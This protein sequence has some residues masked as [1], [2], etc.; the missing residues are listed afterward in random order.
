[1][2]GGRAPRQEVPRDVLRRIVVLDV[3]VVAVAAVAAATLVGPGSWDVHPVAVAVAIAAFAI[4]EAVVVTMQL[5]GSA[6]AFSLSEAPLVAGLL[7]LPAPVLLLTRVVGSAVA[8]VAV[9]RQPPFKVVFNLA[10][11]VAETAFAVGLLR[12]IGISGPGDAGRGLLLVG[13]VA[14]LTGVWGSIYMLAVAGAVSGTVRVAGLSREVAEALAPALAAGAFGLVTAVL[15]QVDPLLLVAQAALAAVLAMA[16]RAHVRLARTTAGLQRLQELTRSLTGSAS[17]RTTAAELAERTREL[18]GSAQAFVFPPGA[19]GWVASAP[20]ETVPP[21]PPVAEQLDGDCMAVPL[22]GKGGGWLVASGRAVSTPFGEEERRTLVM[23]ANHAAVALASA[24][25]GD[26]LRRER[27]EAAHRASHDE[28]TGL[29]NR[30]A[31]LDELQRRLAAGRPAS[32]IILDLDDFKEINDSLGHSAGDEM[33][34]EVARRYQAACPADAVLAR[35]GGDEFAV[36]LPTASATEAVATARALLASMTEPVAVDDLTV[37]VKASAGVA[38]GTAEATAHT[39]LQQ[40]DIAMYDAKAG[41]TGVRLYGPSDHDSARRQLLVSSALREALRDGDVTLAYQPQ[42]DLA[43]RRVVG[44]EAL[45]RWTHP[46]LGPVAPDEFVRAAEHGGLIH[47]LSAFVL[48]TAVAQQRAWADA[49]L[50][51]RMAVNLSPRVLLDAR[52]PDQVGEVLARHGVAPSRLV[53]ELTEGSVLS[54]PQRTVPVLERLSA[55]GI[56]IALDDFGTGYSSLSYL[57]TLPVDQL[58]IDKS[59]VTP[60]ASQ[61]DARPLVTAIIRLCH[62]LDLEV[63]AEGVEDEATAALLARLGCTRIQGWF[64]GRPVPA[65]AVPDLVAADLPELRV[66]RDLRVV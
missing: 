2:T 31:V 30:W 52:L 51:L 63:V 5:G 35:L 19:P 20:P 26:A 37:E 14:V 58:K 39:L 7:I 11:I 45:A 23:L 10:V 33:L 12:L 56:T 13:A 49:G 21:P 61:H 16:H 55:L 66:P 47:D 64:L 43:T 50:D 40:A 46:E 44:V 4:A 27:D 53:L 48:D 38:C 59:F 25:R 9:R 8:L 42:G 62:D 34:R 41:G 1:M 65:A 18:L 29:R 60:L 22:P 36:L 6:Q 57:R 32:L 28:L 17:V 24:A 15:M 54:D 3:A